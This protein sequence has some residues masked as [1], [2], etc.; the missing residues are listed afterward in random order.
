MLH[1]SANNDSNL[2]RQISD[3]III[4]SSGYALVP[5]MAQVAHIEQ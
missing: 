2:L 3:R 4:F 5:L 1:F